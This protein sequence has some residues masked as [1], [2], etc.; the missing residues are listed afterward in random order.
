MCVFVIY[1]VS[2]YFLQN[3]LWSHVRILESLSSAGETA[4]VLVLVTPCLF[5]ATWVTA[6]RGHQS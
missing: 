3:I 6:W 5:P 2:V 4:T 1:I